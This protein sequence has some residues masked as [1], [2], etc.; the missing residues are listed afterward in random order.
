MNRVE[1]METLS[2]LLQDIPEEDRIDA[3]KYYNDYFDD[4]GSE[5]EQNVI[6]ELESPEKVAMK[7]KADREDTED[8]KEG[9]TEKT[10]E[11]AI[12]KVTGENA[13][14]SGARE[15]H[16]RE[17]TYQYYQ[18]D[19]YGEEKDNKIYQDNG[20][21]DYESQEKKP[22]TNK[23][24]KLAMII[25][26]VV[27]GFPIV[28]PLGAGILALIAGIV[29]AVFCL[30]AAIVIGFAAVVMVGVVLFAAGIGSLF[31]NPGVGL[32]V[33]GAG[34]MVIAIGVI[35]TVVGVRLCIIVFPGIVRGIVYIL[36]KTFH[37]KAVA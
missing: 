37:R 24:L 5:N 10:T 25:A 28:I 31:A 1:F 32:A 9:G 36:R 12:G 20:T 11:E 17:N 4:A 30:F 7:I 34:L 35:G 26:I 22:W 19:T 2:R 3:L 23:W 29:I 33:L 27:I 16:D 18:E 13:A 21:Y 6:E 8:G 14:Y 15:Q